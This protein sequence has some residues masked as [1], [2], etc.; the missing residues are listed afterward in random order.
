MS[1][2]SDWL[3]TSTLKTRPDLSDSVIPSEM[4]SVEI[5]KPSND[6]WSYRTITLENGLRC[7]LVSDPEADKAAC[8]MDVSP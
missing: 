3:D 2:W 8:S 5:V 6:T 1:E 7:I 4:S